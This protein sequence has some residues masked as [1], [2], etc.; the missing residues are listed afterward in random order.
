M[1]SNHSFTSN[2]TYPTTTKVTTTKTTVREFDADERCVKETTTEVTETTYQNS[3]NNPVYY[4][5]N[6]PLIKNASTFEVQNPQ[7]TNGTAS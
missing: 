3:W 4:Q 2:H 1:H 5:A 6:Y 7:R